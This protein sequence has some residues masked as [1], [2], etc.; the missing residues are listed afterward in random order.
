MKITFFSNFL[1]HHQ[2][3]FSKAMVELIG[4]GYTFV[5]TTPI[6]QERLEMGYRDQNQLYP[7]ILTT[8]D[9]RE[10]LKKAKSLAE[11]SDVVIIGSAP[12]DFIVE[13]LRHGKLTFRY[14]ERYFKSG[15]KITTLPRY[16]LSAM[17]HIKRFQNRPLYYLCT[18]AYT[19][20]DVNM[21]ANF[22]GKTF[23][24]GYFPETKKYNLEDLFQKKRNNKRPIILWAGRLIDWKHPELALELAERL[25]E[26]NYDFDLEIIG[27]GPLKTSIHQFV[28]DQGLEDYVHILGPKPPE[29]VREYMEAANVFLFTSDFNEGWGVVLN[30]SMNSGCAVVAS[31][32]IGAVP[33]LIEHE[34]N[35]LI[36]QNG[37][38]NEIFNLVKDLIES[39]E[40]REEL[41]KNAYKTIVER[42]SANIAAKRL[43]QLI[44]CIQKG[45]DT[46]YKNG[47]CSTAE[48]LK[49]NWK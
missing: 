22:K 1:N 43:L 9:K 35:G 42:W 21:F 36:Y 19:A 31:H 41:G 16:F 17:R 37:N 18:S 13:R 24:W 46:P 6:P 34:K 44:D 27:E 29:K 3:P 11:S 40:K 12:D 14:S 33:F 2:L 49:N 10:N 45:E 4:E 25:K 26:E 48:I 23:K 8:Y 47:I 28:L 32:A 39:E 15:M 7:F 5:A 20:A 30:E 38:K